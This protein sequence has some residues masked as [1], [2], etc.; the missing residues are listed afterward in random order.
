MINPSPV[1]VHNNFG[2]KIVSVQKN[3][4]CAIISFWNVHCYYNNSGPHLIDINISKTRRPQRQASL[5]L[6]LESLALGPVHYNLAARLEMLIFDSAPQMADH[7]SIAGLPQAV[8]LT[9]EKLA[10]FSPEESGTASPS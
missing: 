3:S 6:W 8:T 2:S 4:K 5:T 7:G 10:P 1:C 9:S